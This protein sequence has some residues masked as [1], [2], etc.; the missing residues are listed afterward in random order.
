[1]DIEFAHAYRQFHPCLIIVD[2][3]TYHVIYILFKLAL[4]S[5]F[6]GLQLA[7]LKK[8]VFLSLYCHEIYTVVAVGLKNYNHT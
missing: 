6:K 5:M 2:K 4:F 7:K 8:T 3:H 1:M